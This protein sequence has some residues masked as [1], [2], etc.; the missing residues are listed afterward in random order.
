MAHVR[1]TVLRELR[2]H[3][4]ADST[5]GE[6]AAADEWLPNVSVRTPHPNLPPATLGDASQSVAHVGYTS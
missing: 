1:K 4:G 3:F 6:R 5:V 2:S